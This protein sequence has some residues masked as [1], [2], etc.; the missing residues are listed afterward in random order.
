MGMTVSLQMSLRNQP[1]QAYSERCAHFG[2]L[3]VCFFSS[4]LR[5]LTELF[6]RL[7]HSIFHGRR[8]PCYA[9][10]NTEECATIVRRCSGGC[11]PAVLG[12]YSS[13][14]FVVIAWI[15]ASRRAPDRWS[16]NGHGLLV[17]FEHAR[18]YFLLIH[19]VSPFLSPALYICGETRC[20]CWSWLDTGS[21]L[22]CVEDRQG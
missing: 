4:Y 6:R 8:R 19:G 13:C 12:D 20:S 17:C 18:L 3:T 21:I 10:G 1:P 22:I 5:S 15:D 2:L 16:R 11:C 9:A 7:L 14:A